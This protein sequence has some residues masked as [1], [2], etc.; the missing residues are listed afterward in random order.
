MYCLSCIKNLLSWPVSGAIH[1]SNNWSQ[2]EIFGLFVVVF[3]HNLG[4]PKRE[5]GQE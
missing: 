1:P 3:F 5:R 2:I 4:I